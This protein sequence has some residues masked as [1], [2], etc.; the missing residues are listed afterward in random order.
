MIENDVVRLNAMQTDEGTIDR[1][2]FFQ[3]F[4]HVNRNVQIQRR[5]NDANRLQ[6]FDQTDAE[7]QR[8]DADR[9]EK[10]PFRIRR[11]IFVRRELNAT[12]DRQGKDEQ[13]HDDDETDCR[14]LTILIF[15]CQRIERS[16]RIRRISTKMFEKFFSELNERIS[17]HFL[18]ERQNDLRDRKTVEMWQRS[19]EFG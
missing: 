6:I 2:A 14:P 8:T 15:E 11:P 4:V 12:I 9:E 5:E 10:N 19:I 16:E 7:K 17:F 3:T 1:T 13:L 18:D